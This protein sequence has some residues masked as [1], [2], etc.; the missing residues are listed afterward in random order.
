MMVR[1]SD[2]QKLDPA[3]W[4]TLLR[5]DPRNESISVKVVR[6]EKLSHAPTLTRYL[7]TL[8]GHPEP[9]SLIGK[10]TN[11]GEARF[12]Q[13]ASDQ[14]PGIVPRC[15]FSHVTG[16][17]SW[18]LVDEVHNDHR[19]ANW[20]AQD[21]EWAL[22]DLATLHATFWEHEAYL[23]SLGWHK[24]LA[25]TI[26]GESPD[27]AAGSDQVTSPQTRE[28]PAGSAKSNLRF[29]EFRP[30]RT[31][32]VSS[33]A[34]QAAGTLARSFLQ[35]ADGL[36]LLRTIGGWPGILKEKHLLAFADLLDDPVP[37]LQIL[38]EQPVT[39]LHGNPAA[40]KWHLGLLGERHLVGWQDVT[41]GPAVYDL[42]SFINQF[43]LLNDPGR[44]FLVRGEWPLSEETMID[45]YLLDMGSLLGTDFQA[46]SVRRAIPAARCLHVMLTWLPR[47]ANWLAMAGGE[48]DTWQEMTHMTDED[49]LAS[50]FSEMV[51]LRPYFG[52]LF[53]DFFEAYRAL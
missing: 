43:P 11:S 52:R 6:A 41:I 37:M 5:E 28:K 14:L 30:G 13:D 39:L 17:R 46:T 29:Q 38:R 51:A 23:S 12:F 36:R 47:L 33:H 49:L 50:G 16:G 2:L 48:R 42:V 22:A 21:V 25:A 44:G 20:T 7:I 15:W 34:L 1:V 40:D 9:V 53:E 31:E 45:S 26:D 8:D 24:L 27:P 19:P 3:A 10:Q 32:L 35:V 18:I 4:T